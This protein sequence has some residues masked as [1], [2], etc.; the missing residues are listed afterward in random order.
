MKSQ[1]SK[2][3][4]KEKNK[5][6]SSISKTNAGENIFNLE[7]DEVDEENISTINGDISKSD[8][9]EV[10]N[11]KIYEESFDKKENLIIIDY[12]E[13]IRMDELKEILKKII[14]ILYDL[15]N[16]IKEKI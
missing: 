3:N 12:K 15:L 1:K 2:I 14:A 7:F 11:S 5:L 16:N 10:S 6:K 13:S 9:N 8:Q 4:D